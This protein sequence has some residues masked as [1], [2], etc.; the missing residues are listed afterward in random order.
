MFQMLS[1]ID[2]QKIKKEYGE[3]QYTGKFKDLHNFI[4]VHNCQKKWKSTFLHVL[5]IRFICRTETVGLSTCN[6]I[7]SC[8]FASIEYLG[9]FHEKQITFS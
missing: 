7:S 2:Y 6:N 3:A 8:Y 5:A 9:P 4:K 1:I